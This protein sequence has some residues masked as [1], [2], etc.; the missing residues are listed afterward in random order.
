MVSQL[1][2]DICSLA[3]DAFCSSNRGHTRGEEINS[4]VSWV[5]WNREDWGGRRRTSND[6]SLI[7]QEKFRTKERS[8]LRAGA[9]CLPSPEVGLESPFVKPVCSAGKEVPH[10]I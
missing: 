6:A 1:T 9:A 5:Q 2:Q 4:Q 7:L 8:C 3:L 10:P